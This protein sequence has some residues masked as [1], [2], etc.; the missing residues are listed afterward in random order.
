MALLIATLAEIAERP[1]KRQSLLSGDFKD[2]AND[3]NEGDSGV[4]DDD[5]IRLRVSN[6]LFEPLEPSEE[7]GRLV[8][9]SNYAYRYPFQHLFY[10]IKASFFVP[11]PIGSWPVGLRHRMLPPHD[12]KC[13]DRLSWLSKQL[14]EE[15]QRTTELTSHVDVPS[16]ARGEEGGASN[17]TG[18]EH[19]PSIH[20]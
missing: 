17:A 8:A 2:S 14:E 1:Y 12:P 7:P 18:E 20:V 11:W 10:Y 16:A 6:P 19:R 15:Q 3:R 13:Q 5:D 9:G 4:V